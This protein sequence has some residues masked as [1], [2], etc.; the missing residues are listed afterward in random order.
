MKANVSAFGIGALF[1]IGLA[2]SGMTRPSKVLGFLD[3]TGARDGTWDPSLALVMVGAIVV[4][5]AT[6][7]LL[8]GRTLPPFGSTFHLPTKRDIDSKLI[9][10]SALFGIGWGL[11]GYCPGPGLTSAVGGS[12]GAIVFVAGMSIGMLVHGRIES[13]IITRT[14]LREFEATIGDRP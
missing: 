8:N 14:S 12:L 11:G 2:V 5:F 13:H 6:Q 7:R 10:G 3:I 9:V 4:H 1:A